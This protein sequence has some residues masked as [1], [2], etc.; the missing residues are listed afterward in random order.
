SAAHRPTGA[1]IDE[2]TSQR[3][4]PIRRGNRILAQCYGKSNTRAPRASYRSVPC[5]ADRGNQIGGRGSIV[6]IRAA[7]DYRVSPTR[8]CR[9]SSR[10]RCHREYLTIDIG[11]HERYVC[12]AHGPRERYG[13]R[14]IETL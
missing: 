8:Q 3:E 11:R 1:R 7:P 13:L 2:T 4:C 5:A 9:V 12:T 6:P 10:C 14:N